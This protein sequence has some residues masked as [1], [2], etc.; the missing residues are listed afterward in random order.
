[1]LRAKAIYSNVRRF[2]LSKFTQ[3][4]L[5]FAPNWLQNT[6][7]P[8]RYNAKTIVSKDIKIIKG[9]RTDT[10]EVSQRGVYL[11]TASWSVSFNDAAL[12]RCN[13]IDFWLFKNG[14]AY[15]R[16]DYENLAI[17]INPL[18]DAWVYQSLCH[19]NGTVA[20]YLEKHDYFDIRLFFTRNAAGQD[21]GA[22]VDHTGSL[23]VFYYDNNVEVL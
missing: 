21:W 9:S 14:V 22:W 20:V 1:M 2:G 11:V 15:E 3:S 12:K 16:I 6:W 13:D 19:L 7:N 8:V 18:T 17:Q 23:S 4:N 5:S 10:F